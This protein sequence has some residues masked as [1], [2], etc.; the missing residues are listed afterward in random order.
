MALSEKNTSQRVVIIGGGAIGIC[1]AYYLHKA[2]H[3]V[4]VLERGEIGGEC[5]GGNAGLIVPSHFVPLAAPGVISQGIRWLFNPQSP[6]YIKPRLNIE[7]L[8]WLWQFRGACSDKRMQAAIPLLHQLLQKTMPLFDELSAL[9]GVEF[10]M[11][12]QGLLILYSGD[13]G[14]KEC[15]HLQTMGSQIGI[16]VDMLDETELENYSAVLPPGTRGG[17]FFP[18]DIHIH[19]HLFVKS[20]AEYLQ[21]EG[22]EIRD[23]LSVSGFRHSARKITAV[24]TSGG[25]IE[26]GQI[27]LA[28]GSWTPELGKQL[29]RRIPIQPARGYSITLDAPDHGLKVPMIVSEA[30][31]TITPLANQ[32]RFSGTL[33]LAGMDSSIDRG[34]VMPILRLIPH[35]IPELNLEDID[36]SE[37]WSGFRPCTPDGLPI[38]GPVSGF[39]NLIVA[40]GHAM[41]G[42]TLAPVTGQLVAELLGGPPTG[43]ELAP[44]RLE[45]F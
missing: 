23:N 32:L 19:P 39:D 42:I 37:I 9:P 24:K 44:L 6:F 29:G 25:D 40:A 30:K 28:A 3:R 31:A 17:A 35:F 22:V 11:Q 12:K 36:F 26:A 10:Q 1:T 2:G 34:R 16:P 41:I 8:R 14:L 15:Q 13:K 4:I 43:I 18:Q 21:K 27:I 33:S 38:I 20:L 7:L 45:R 5:S